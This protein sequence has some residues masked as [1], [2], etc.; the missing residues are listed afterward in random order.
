MN[1]KEALEKLNSGSK[2]TRKS[3]NDKRFLSLKE[4]KIECSGP[5][6]SSYSYDCT[7]YLSEGWLIDDDSKEHKFCDIIDALRKGSKA[8]LKPW[9]DAYIFYDRNSKELVMHHLQNTNFVP[10]FESILS[11]D[12][13]EL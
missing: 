12:W 9:A 5:T 2:I 6:F 1:F 3:W 4:D 10:D 7:L 8:K 13:I 11:N